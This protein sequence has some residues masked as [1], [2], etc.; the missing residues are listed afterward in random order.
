MDVYGM[1]FEDFKKRGVSDFFFS[2][3]IGYSE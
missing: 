1:F 2:D 3:M